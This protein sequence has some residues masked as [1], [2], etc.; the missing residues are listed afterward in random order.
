[1][2]VRRKLAVAV[3]AVLVV[4]GV[5]VGLTIGLRSRPAGTAT[6]HAVSSLLSSTQQTRLERGLTASTVTAQA[7]SLA[8]E[9]RS[10]FEDRGEPLLP[11]GSH[12][13]IDPAT[14]HML[15]AQLATVDATVSGPKPGHWQLVL[16]RESGQ[17]LLIG[18]RKLS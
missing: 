8:L 17:W 7:D 3:I 6:G 15:S 13:S 5:G 18:T 2:S 11:A 16:V 9:V 1:M 4:A 14:F 10:K 12:V